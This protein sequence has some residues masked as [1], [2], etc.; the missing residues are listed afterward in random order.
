MTRL[1]VES[2]LRTY[3]VLVEQGLLQR[4]ADILQ[5]EGL[6]SPMFLVITDDHVDRAGHV[7]RMVKSLEAASLFVDTISVPSG[8][9]SK[10]LAMAEF[11]YSQLATRR[12]RRN[13]VILAVGG[14]VVGDLA[15]F[16]AST[17]LRGIRYVQVPTT[18]LAHDSAIGG[19]VGVN[20]AVGKNLVGSFYAPWAILMDPETLATLPAREWKSGMAEV[21]KHAILGDE[22]LFQELGDVPYSEYPGPERTEDLLARAMRVKVKVVSEDE[23]EQGP[24]ML[25][26]I[27]HNVGHA[28]ESWSHYRWSHG[29]AVA[30]GLAVEAHLAVLMGV[31]SPAD[32]DA[33][34][35]VLTRHGLPIREK[36]VTFE[37][38]R[39]KLEMDKKNTTSGWTFAL[40]T[41]IGRAE[42]FHDV[43]EALVRR[44]WTDM[45]DA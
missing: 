43:P 14:G 37:D 16:V 27:G 29:E 36:S 13:T 10:S 24:R 8:E 11:L 42:I 30:I 23:H 5:S 9:A 35:D 7:Q 45:Y 4:T 41:G 44:A 33:I 40:P 15:G 17:Y 38:L 18:L 2:Q 19:K 3:P 21:I 22:S 26:N 1:W 25:L 28:V 20:L 39:S 34:Q 12:V 32:R 6:S 31:L